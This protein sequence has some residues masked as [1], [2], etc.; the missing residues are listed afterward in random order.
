MLQEMGQR[1]FLPDILRCRGEALFALDRID[2]AGIVLAEALSL[3]E[4]QNSRRA[5]WPIL[6]AM[7][8]YANHSGDGSEGERLR[9]RARDVI[10]YIADRAGSPESTAAF[11]NS[12]KVRDLIGTS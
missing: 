11:L 7:A 10:Q 4:E 3:A 2:E 5:I 9:S 8:R 6:S 1:V 12:P